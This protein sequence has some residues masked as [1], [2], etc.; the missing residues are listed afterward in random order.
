[1]LRINANFVDPDI[2]RLIV[3]EVNGHPKLV[4]RQVQ[5]LRAEL[6]CPGN[7]FTLKIIAEGKI[8]HHLKECPMAC[9]N[10]DVIDITGADA[11]LTGGHAFTRRRH[12]AG[13]IFFH[14]CHAGINKQQTVV[15]LRDQWEAWKAKVPF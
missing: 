9:G 8:A 12:L 3:I 1:M 5:H 2:A 14:W 11:F 10:A 13:K 15:V 6:P 7:R 4:N